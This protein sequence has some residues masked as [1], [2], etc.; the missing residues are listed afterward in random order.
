MYMVW[1]FFQ[2]FL[3]SHSF[4]LDP[5]CLDLYYTTQ[6]L[7]AHNFNKGEIQINFWIWFKNSK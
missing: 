4:D 3:L 6:S 2:Y 1:L 7:F 5:L